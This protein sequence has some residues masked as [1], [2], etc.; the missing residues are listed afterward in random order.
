MVA[1]TREQ[2]EDVFHCMS[3][4][5][6]KEYQ[7]GSGTTYKILIENY[8]NTI[9]DVISLDNKEIKT[10]YLSTTKIKAKQYLT[11]SQIDGIKYLK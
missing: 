11:M 10:I 4:I 7:D 2:H 5:E 9:I 8:I 3:L 6:N 1:T